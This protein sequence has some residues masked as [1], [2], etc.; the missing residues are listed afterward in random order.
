MVIFRYEMKNHLKY[1]LSWSAA[2]A[3]CIFV[4]IPIYYSLPGIAKPSN[5]S[6]YDTL[7]STDFFQSIG[8]SPD[9]LT[10]PLG[11]YSFLT[12]F[13]MIAAGIFGMHFGI[14]IH[15]KEFSG[16]TSEYLFTKPHARKDIFLSKALAVFCSVLIVGIFF[17]SAS[18]L[19]LLLF[20]PGFPVWEF[21]LISK[22]LFLVTL[23]LAAFGLLTGIAFS[24]NR[25]PLL[26]AGLTVFV[27]YCI[28]S[29]SRI[30]GNRLLS[31]LSPYSF[32]SAAEISRIGFY[33]LDYLIWYFVLFVIF[34]VAA[35]GI[36][37]KK[38][39]PLRS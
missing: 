7:G 34:L 16:K 9:Y 11:V 4:M 32:F 13:F 2:L 33:E 8:F 3:V 12:S 24:A 20:R 10:T 35:Y 38:D 28:T 36:F 39:V 31:F 29:L 18:F 21:F 14:S 30:I 27:E 15:T 37:L 26:T 25:S 1:I 17:L 5:N 19:A 23:F 6:L 22:S